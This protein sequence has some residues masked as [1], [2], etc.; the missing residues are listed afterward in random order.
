M[1]IALPHI[2]DNNNRSRGRRVPVRTALI[3]ALILL[4][5][6]GAVRI[7]ATP[8]VP[9][10]LT[11]RMPTVIALHVPREFAQY[12]HKEERHGAKWEVAIGTGQAETLTRLLQAMFEEVIVVSEVTASADSR[13]RAVLEPAVDEYSF[14]T[15]RDAGSPVYAVSIKYRINIYT[16]QGRLADSW[17]FTGYGSVA[18]DSGFDRDEPMKRA[19]E[20]AIRDAGAKLVA[21][22]RDQAAIRQVLEDK[23][24]TAS[25]VPA[26]TA[27]PATAPAP[28]KVP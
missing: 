28:E 5:G 3:V 6:C 13:V 15:P 12:L 11:Y 8:H 26:A 23:P 9:A 22:F 18:A 7:T 4:G 27:E 16:A 2:R 21:E 20:L 19:T 24:E 14:I 1:V 10:P 17:G 25:P